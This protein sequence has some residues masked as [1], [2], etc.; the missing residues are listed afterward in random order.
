MGYPIRNPH[1]SQDLPPINR[2]WAFNHP[3]AMAALKTGCIFLSPTPMPVL[4]LG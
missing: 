2:M 3:Q 4:N 1:P